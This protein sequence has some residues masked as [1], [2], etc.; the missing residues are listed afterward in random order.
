MYIHVYLCNFEYRYCKTLNIRGIK[1]L[2]LN[3]NDILAEINF[4]IHEYH[5]PR[6]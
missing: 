4:C 3:G 6:K 5:G 2:R 1:V